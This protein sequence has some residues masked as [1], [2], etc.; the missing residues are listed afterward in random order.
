[1][2]DAPPFAIREAKGVRYLEF[3]PDSLQG[4][5]RLARPSAL[6]FEYTRDMLFGLLLYPGD[7]PRQ[8]LVIGIGAGAHVRFLHRHFPE[9]RI[10]ALEIHPGVLAAARQFFKLPAPSPRFSP[11]LA[12]AANWIKSAPPGHFDLILLDAFVADGPPAALETP[13]FLTA[14]QKRL[15]TTGI[16]AANRLSGSADLAEG[17]R[18]IDTAFAGHSRA[19]PAD[20]H[21]N[22]VVLASRAPGLVHSFA[23]LHENARA[24]RQHTGL[25]LEP[26]LRRLQAITPAG[27]DLRL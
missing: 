23:E 10:T 18:R 9:T 20:A 16:F 3:G 24:L 17:L 13:D 5:M 4:A 14:C 12:D 22:V 11:V 25:D 6:E 8:V 27:A 1:V 7:W 2:K 26:C 15:G 21:G 19:L